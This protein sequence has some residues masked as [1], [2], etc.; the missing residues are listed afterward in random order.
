MR[1][2]KQESADPAVQGLEEI[3]DRYGALLFRVCFSELQNRQ[4]AED[5]VQEIFLKLLRRRPVFSDSDH[6]RAWLIRTAVNQS[7]D[8][9]RLRKVRLAVPLEELQEY[10]LSEEETG[11]LE[12]VMGLPDKYRLA[13]TLHYLE[14][15]SV[16]ETAVMLRISESAVKMRLSRGR[17]LL[18]GWKEDSHV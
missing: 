1:F 8:Q 16:K 11:F 5:A 7:R 3:Y 12:E 13:V 6:Q 18:K 17:E 10:A 2:K 4:D 15:Y 9:L 14:G